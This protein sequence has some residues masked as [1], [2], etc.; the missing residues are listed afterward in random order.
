MIPAL[1]FVLTFMP[2][3][4]LVVRVGWTGHAADSERVPLVR[5]ARVRSLLAAQESMNQSVTTE[6]ALMLV[7]IFM[8]FSFFRSGWFGPS[9][10]DALG[11]RSSTEHIALGGQIAQ[12]MS[13]I[14][15]QAG[16]SNLLSLLE[17]CK[18]LAAVSPFCLPG[19]WL[20]GYKD[21]GGS[22]QIRELP[23]GRRR[24]VPRPDPSCPRP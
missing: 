22:Y 6:P 19:S 1:T 7:L 24:I 13:T 21:Q 14:F 16:R 10:D 9:R 2:F 5:I 12:K 11:N 4:F 15:F 3:S 23:H 17:A 18:E 8:V 20:G